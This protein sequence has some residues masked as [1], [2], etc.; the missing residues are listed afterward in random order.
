M[1]KIYVISLD[2]E[3]GKNRRDLLNYEYTWFKG[4]DGDFPE[5]E[6]LKK[7]YIRPKTSKKFKGQNMGLLILIIDY[8]KK[9]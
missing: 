6:I 4:I 7:V 5:E 9:L 8:L 1:N 3:L 2:N